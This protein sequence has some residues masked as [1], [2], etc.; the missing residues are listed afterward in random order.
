MFLVPIRERARFV[1]ID[2]AGILTGL[3]SVMLLGCLPVGVIVQT[4]L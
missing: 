4:P 2:D 1:N 3:N